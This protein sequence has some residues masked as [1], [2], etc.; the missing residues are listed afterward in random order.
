[1]AKRSEVVKRIVDVSYVHAAAQDCLPGATSQPMYQVGD[2]VIVDR[3][4][5]AS[6][7][8]VLSSVSAGTGEFTGTVKHD[9]L[10]EFVEGQEVSFQ[11]R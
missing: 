4:G 2:V 8:I 6:V 1:M 5:E 7:T 3:V 9:M 11:F 10:P